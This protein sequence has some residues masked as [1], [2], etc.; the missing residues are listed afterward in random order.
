MCDSLENVNPGR[1]KFL[2]FNTWGLKYVSKFRKQRLTAIAEKL[3]GNFKG[4]DVWG[5]KTGEEAEEY[6]VVALQ[7]VWCEEDWDY[8]AQKCKGVYPYQRIFKS[9]MISGPGLA[10]LSKIPIE[11]TFLYRFPINGRPSAFWRGDWYVGKSISITLLKQTSPLYAPM[12]ILN[13]HMHA[14]YSLTGDAAYECHRACQSWDFSKLVNLY[15]QA[16]YSVVVVGDLNSRPGSLPHKFLTLETGLVDSW[17]QKFGI[18][19]LSHIAKLSPPAQITHGG[20]TCDST[21]NSWRANRD[22]TEACRLDYALIDSNTLV[23]LDAG[24]RFTEMIPSV[25]SF[26]DHFAYSCVL[27]LKEINN[28]DKGYNNLHQHHSAHHSPEMSAKLIKDRIKIYDEMLLCIECYMKTAKW[29]KL[30]RGWHFWISVLL[31]I[32]TVVVTTFTSNIAGWSSIFWILFAVFLTASG[33]IDGL[34]SFLFGNKEIRGLQE[35][36]EEVTDAKRFLVSTL[37]S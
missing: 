23:T 29:Q 10:I 19:D 4:E 26:S 22:P 16:G 27:Q 1:I 18:Q 21:L 13:S 6:D 15:K 28:D 24:V 14:P 37:D 2:T 12:A 31:I 17:E 3:A 32:A 9:G 36:Y 11:S 30:W 35:V 34:I 25:G 7:E 5:L 20:T 33:L 8:I